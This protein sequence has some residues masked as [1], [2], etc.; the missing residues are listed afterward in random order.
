MKR[1]LQM[2]LAAIGVLG[3]VVVA[4]VVYVT[5]FLD[6]EDFKPRLVEVVRDQSGLELTLDGPLS[7]SFYPR[8]GVSVEQAEGRLP[9]QSADDQPFLAFSRAEVSLAFAPLLRGEIAIEG[10]TLDGM[11]LRLER[12]EQGHGNWETLM[13][14]LDERREG[15]ESALAPASAGPSLEGSNLAVA[16]NIASVQVRN[17]AAKYRDLAEGTE[18]LVEEINLSGTN[19]NPQRAFP[20]RS[21]F[22]LRSYPSLDWRELERSP[23]LASDISLEGRM[24]LALAE[25]RYVLEGLKLNTASSLAGIEGRQQLDLS[26]QQLILDLS[27]QRLQLQEGRL[28]AGLQHPSLGDNPVPLVLVMA[29]DADL[30]E[31]TAQLRELQLTG[32]DEL[33]LSG[34]LNLAGLNQAPTYSGQIS[35]A[36]FSLRPWLS[37]LDRMPRMA[38]PQALSDVA[39]TS[40]VRGNLER[41][42]L[43]G[44]TMVLDGSTFTGRLTAGFDGQLLDFELQGDRLNLDSYLPPAEPVDQSAARRNLL[45]IGKAHADDT[46]ELVPAE[47]L[48]QLDLNGTLD[49]AQLRLSGLD[50][51]EVGLAMSGGDGQQRL[52]RFSSVFYDGELSASGALDLTRE[53]IRWQLRPSLSRVRLEPLLKALGED[54]G[55][56]PLRGRLTLGG[57]LDTRANNWPALKRNLNGR[58]EGR[59]DE[60]AIL[61]VN[62]S[63]ELCSLAAMIEGNETTRDWSADT[64]FERAE[65]S[66]RITDGVARSEDILVL[67]PG[68]E[69]DGTG[70]LDLGSERFDLRA[71]A[72]FVDG[73]DAACPVNPRLERVPLPVRCSGELSGDTGEWCSF[74]REAFQVTLAELLRD[75]VSGRAREELERRLERPL[76]QLEERLGEGAGRELR[77]TLRGLLN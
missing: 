39:L 1:L 17:G 14:R 37:R 57:E 8:L 26:G 48:A 25:R 42:E 4:A 38:G 69:L 59:I 44:L 35:V 19:V 52:E 32:P 49:L 77:D 47:W 11:Q 9:E 29:L 7:W 64:R 70:E 51:T 27:Q 74:D 45:G 63:Q 5:T 55:P 15:A 75:E 61:D 54:N 76:E 73:A 30:A 24:R 58:L 40:P 53:P 23:A 50:F 43:A 12:D 60:G 36:P 56:A 65:A 31:N 22:R 3:V 41:L 71:A 33:R 34:H 21:S 66:L 68:I 13:Q 28:E 6:P 46:A 18:W 62:V 72:R 2:L 10:L 67:I 20:F 16:L